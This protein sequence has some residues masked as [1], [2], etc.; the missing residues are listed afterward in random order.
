MQNATLVDL[1]QYFRYFDDLVAAAA[2]SDQSVHEW[3]HHLLACHDELAT[4][5]V[6]QRQSVLEEVDRERVVGLMATGFFQN[7]ALDERIA[8][9]TVALE[10]EQAVQRL[11][12]EQRFATYRSEQPLFRAQPGLLVSARDHELLPITTL[13]PIDD[14]GVVKVGQTFCRLDQM[15]PAAIVRWAQETHLGSPIFIRVDPEI[16]S[17]TRPRP[18]V[19][20]A[21][22]VP[23]DPRWWNGLALYP[24]KKTGGVYR[25]DPPDRPGDDAEAYLE[26]HNRGLRRLET[27]AQRSKVT[28][29]SMMLEELEL[30]NGLL[31]GRCIHCD[32]S[33]P[34]GTT[35]GEARLAHIDLA[36]NVYAGPT[37]E[38]RLGEHLSN[39]KV[40]D[41]TFRT[42]LL[43]LESVP[44][45]TVLSLAFMF[46]RSN[47][48]VTEMVEDQFRGPAAN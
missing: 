25:L 12:L 39:G 43:R 37:V 7:L 44:A 41:A 20:E 3:L 16:A 17:Q 29:L 30:S 6:E 9:F 15:L 21:V 14:D 38:T 11:R 13:G 42:H 18:L 46:F 23:A 27:I 35:P 10:L 47:R 8:A 4:R 45:D 22:L 32:T 36:V 26:Y 24:R 40:V 1:D 34:F 33:A 2:R 5:I 19:Q 48:L 28:Y 31:I